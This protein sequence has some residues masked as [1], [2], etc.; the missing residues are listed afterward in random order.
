M[1]DWDKNFSQER[2]YDV[3]I[4]MI[5]FSEVIKQG[6]G[7]LLLTVNDPSISGAQAGR[8]TFARGVDDSVW[9]KY[10]EGDTDW[11]R[12]DVVDPETGKLDP[13][14]LPPSRE[15]PFPFAAF[16]L[17]MSQAEWRKAVKFTFT[18]STAVTGAVNVGNG[19]THVKLLRWDGTFSAVK[20]V[21]ASTGINPGDWGAAPASPYNSRLPKFGA[22][23]PCDVSG[24][25]TGDLT[26]LDLTENQLTSVD[27]LGL[28]ELTSLNLVF[29]QL[30]SAVDVSG[31][32][33]LTNLNLSL[34]QLTSVRALGVGEN[35]MYYGSYGVIDIS[36]NNLSAEALN[37]L[38]ADLVPPSQ[39]GTGLSVV[40]NPGAATSNFAIAT[41]KG[42]TVIG[43]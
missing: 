4:I 43:V 30:T 1:R 31:R 35:L 34:N 41:A 36:N 8:G 25:V 3:K 13:A 11:V 26:E 21:S 15:V 10:G 12:I 7:T 14:L 22:I 40:G 18:Q 5:Q 33:E 23:V 24:S 9:C 20:A 37:Q 29:N 2:G 6:A 39:P 28:M 42:Y 16:T 19:A 27:V 38:Y 32:T 17:G